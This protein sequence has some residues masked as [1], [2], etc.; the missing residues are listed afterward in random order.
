MNVIIPSLPKTLFLLLLTTLPIQA[1]A[2]QASC[3]SV[4]ECA[5]VMVQIAHDLAEE[6]RDLRDRVAKLEGQLDTK[7]Q[8]LSDNLTPRITAAEKRIAKVFDSGWFAFGH[9]QSKAFSHGLGGLP[10]GVTIYVSADGK[11][12]ILGDVWVFEN[13]SGRGAGAMD[14]NENTLTVKGGMQYLIDTYAI[15]GASAQRILTQSGQ[16]R[17]IAWA[18]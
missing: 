12:G 7:V 2:Q 14:I 3:G 18:F 6:S 11:N 13:G 4:R 5:D 9:A 8:A 17:V 1:V 10:H 15:N 16:A